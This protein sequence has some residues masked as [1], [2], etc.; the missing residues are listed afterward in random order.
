MDEQ[1]P[2]AVGDTSF[3]STNPAASADHRTLSLDQT[4]LRYDR[5]NK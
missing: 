4:C 1:A 2:L 5:P 3:R